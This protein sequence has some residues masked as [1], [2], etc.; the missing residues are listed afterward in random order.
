MTQTNNESNIKKTSLFIVGWALMLQCAIVAQSQTNNPDDNFAKIAARGI[1]GRKEL[2]CVNEPVRFEKKTCLLEKGHFSSSATTEKIST[3][4]ELYAELKLI[5]EKYRPFLQDLAPPP[6]SFRKRI[7]LKT[8]NLDGKPVTL[9]HYGHPIGN[10]KKTYETSISCE[11]PE[12][13]K[14]AYICFGGADYIA[15]VYVNGVC[16]GRHEGFFSPFEFEITDPLVTGEN[17]IKIELFNDYNYMGFAGEGEKDVEGDKLYAATG[18]GWDD[19]VHGWHHC[20]PGMGLYGKVWVEVRNRVHITDLFIRPMESGVEVWVEAENVDYESLDVKFHLDIFGQNFKEHTVR[21]YVYIPQAMLLRHGKNI[22]KIFVPMDNVKR[23]DLETPWLYQAQVRILVGETLSDV[24]KRQF[25]MRSFEQDVESEPMGMFYLNGRKIRLRGANTMGFEQQ[26]VQRGDLEQLIDDILLAKLCNMNFWRLTQRPVQDEVYEYCDKLGL[27]TQTDLPLF[28]VMR[29]TKFAEG[30]RQAEEMERLVRSHPCN[31]LVTYINEPTPNANGAPHR[32]LTRK[33]M[34]DFFNACDLIVRHNNPDRVI[35]HVDGDY[36]PP[37]DNMPDNHCYTLWY[38][39]HGID[40]GKLH[41]GYWQETAPGW[42][43]GCGEY[44]TEGL[45]FAELMRRRYPAEWLREPFNPNNIIAAQTGNFHYFFYDTQ[46]TLEDWVHESQAHQ[47]FAAR[48]MTEAF[49]RDSRMVSNAIHLFI[50]AWPSGWMKSIMDCERNPKPAYFA[51]RNASEPLMV[52]LRTD[53]FSYYAGEPV[54]IEAHLC[55]DTD[56]AFNGRIVFELYGKN[57]LLRRGEQMVAVQACDAAY[58]CTAEFPANEVNDREEFMLKAVLM[59]TNG[60]VV[61]YNQIKFDV[62][63]DVEVPENK[64]VVIYNNLKPGEY[65]IAG[66][67]VKVTA[68]GMSPVY[69]VSRNTN[70]N[71]V[72][73]FRKRDFSFW[74]NKAEDRISA[75]CAATFEAPGFTPIL[76]GGNQVNNGN[77]QVGW[78]PTLVAA[79]KVFEGKRHIICQVDSRTENPVA[80]RFLRN[81]YTDFFTADVKATSHGS[82]TEASCDG[83]KTMRIDIV[84]PY[85]G[86]EKYTQLWAESERE[87]DFDADPLMGQKCTVSFAATE[88]SRYL[89]RIIAHPDIRF[90]SKESGVFS[91]RL[92]VVGKDCGKKENYSLSIHPDGIDINGDSRVGVLYGVYEVLRQLGVRWLY[93]G[94]EG[95]VLP[96]KIETLNLKTGDFKYA[97][98][99]PLGRGFYLEGALKESGELWLWMARNRLNLCGYRLNTGALQQKLGFTFVNGGHIFEKILDTDKATESGKTLWEAHPDYYG[100]PASGAKNKSNAQSVQFCVT[101][102]G[103]IEYLS[104]AFIRHVN[105][106]Y[107]DADRI[108][109]WGFD[110][111]GSVCQCENCKKLGNGSDAWLYFM[112]RLRTAVDKAAAQGELK[113]NPRL[114]MCSYEGTSTLEPPLNA[115]PANLSNSGDYITF[116]PI[117]R[118]YKHTF[119]GE[120]CDWNEPYYKALA[121]WHGIPVMI[122]EYYNVSKFW[123]LPVLFSRIMEKD[124]AGYADMD[125][126]GFTYMHVPMCCWGV[127]NLTQFLYAELLWNPYADVTHLKQQYFT[128]RYGEAAAIMAEAY[129]DTEEAFALS[130]NFRSWSGKSILSRLLAWDGGV[131]TETLEQGDIH[132][133]NGC[134]ADGLHSVR[135][136]ESA[137]GK[138]KDSRKLLFEAYQSRTKQPDGRLSVNR[139]DREA[140]GK[141]AIYDKRLTDDLRGLVF[142]LDAMEITT[143]LAMYYNALLKGE[144]TEKIWSS[145]EEKAEKMRLYGYG[146]EY[147][148][149]VVELYS[150]D[151]LSYSQLGRVYFKCKLNKPARL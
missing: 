15:V 107:P 81:L 9:P 34:A 38:N 47:A 57:G 42:Y 131:P 14:A 68:C 138:V 121:G 145:I 37:S 30:V 28:S 86:A 110:T 89:N 77:W 103:L 56:T 11:K 40:V 93:P 91:I 100:T 92:K 25:G 70:H 1:A 69:F 50:D 126:Q 149:P 130:A 62:F 83:E 44:G 139:N 2:L 120:K 85:E 143:L 53:R 96:D 36:N 141:L 58:T 73:E 128:D 39:G 80:K 117:N 18:L 116:Y 23:W 66:E 140:S 122:G 127:R 137:I 87:I 3:K 20:P 64:N 52:S 129:A 113:K 76:T 48:L 108:D 24:A 84:L 123:D 43:Y 51:C 146:I 8:F 124:I 33:E 10:G 150:H 135:L 82:K 90:T 118:C 21:D 63:E 6:A 132:F 112:S 31:I 147:D 151:A 7:D 59:E 71:A 16:V 102:E 133:K 97:P 125:V 95:E 99:F 111:W 60:A 41:K 119:A 19:P 49:R 105:H 55:N 74:Y 101:N 78:G 109:V 134:V 17:H 148:S 13:G 67:T 79:E 32:H 46:H 98:A 4:E 5:R 88:L 26:D 61:T 75:I 72:L 142:G 94:I 29:R 22:Y 106:E 45:D 136:L 114:V 27:M 104:K 12:P 54:S 144:D 115:I 65:E 35:K